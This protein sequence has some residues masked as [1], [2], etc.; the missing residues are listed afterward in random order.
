MVSY[1]IPYNAILASQNFFFRSM[2]I[3]IF[4]REGI[5]ASCMGIDNPFFNPVLH[6]ELASESIPS[7]IADINIFFAEHNV[8]WTWLVFPFSKPKNL[9][10]ILSSEGIREVETF[11][12][13]GMNMDK[14]LPVGHVSP[15]SIREVRTSKDFDDWSL[16]LKEGFEA[17]AY[18]ARKFRNLTENILHHEGN[19]FRHYV[20]Y[21]DN[22]PVASG[23]LSLYEGNVRLDNISVRLSYQRQGFGTDIIRYMLSEAKGMNAKYCFL[24]ASYQGIELYKKLGFDEYY[25]GKIFAV[26]SRC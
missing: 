1:P 18:E 4:E 11:A 24:D 5:L 10:E 6:T 19:N 14:R 26:G 25:T 7:T 8:R 20:L 15:C 9:S 23:T 21:A 17:T 13:M 22:A 16:P 2:S 3:A 12:V